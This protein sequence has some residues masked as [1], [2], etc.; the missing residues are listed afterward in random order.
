MRA[1][2]WK[3][4]AVL[5]LSGMAVAHLLALWELREYIA[6]GFSDFASFYTA[7]KLVQRGRASEMYSVRAQ[8]DLQQEFAADAKLRRSPLRYAHLPYE[9]LVFLPFTYFSYP[10][11]NWLWLGFKICILLAIPFLT[12]PFVLGEELFPPVAAVALSIGTFPIAIDLV[13]GQDAILLTLCIAL[14]F[15]ALR[16]RMDFRSGLFLAL[17]LFKFHLI[18]PVVLVFLLKRKWRVVSGFAAG[19]TALLVA[20]LALV[21]WTTLIGYPKYLW[22]LN[23]LPNI[24][25]PTPD[26]MPNLRS[27]LT[28]LIGWLGSP[29]LVVP[30]FLVLGLFGAGFAASLWR[31]DTDERITSAGFSL[32]LVTTI[33]TSYYAYPQDMAW[34]LLPVWVLGSTF[35]RG[36]DLPMSSRAMFIAG[37][38]LLLFSPL[39]WFLEIR[40]SHFSLIAVLI[41]LLL[42]ASLVL[43]LRSWSNSVSHQ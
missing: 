20:S 26:A 25:V 13:L 11:A 36:R 21:G 6:H 38:A 8:W 33:F 16:R 9:A 30:L 17:G 42:G 29:A 7:G 23:A 39:L 1:P 10:V 22:E 3:K 5:F 37:T 43:A 24:G 14:T 12:R 34:L 41:E 32:C 28:A 2:R 35:S 18:V 4:L 40:T 15:R 27:P 31:S 19:G